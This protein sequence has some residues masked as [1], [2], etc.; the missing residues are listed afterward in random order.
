MKYWIL[1][2]VAGIGLLLVPVKVPCGSPGATCAMPPLP[3][4][5]TPRYY[6]EYE[7]LGVLWLELLTQA[8][9]PFYYASGTENG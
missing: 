2:A 1:G 3:G 5:T 4:G 8:N 6:Y 9:L 7:P